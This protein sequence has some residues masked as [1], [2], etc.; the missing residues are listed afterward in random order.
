[1]FKDFVDWNTGSLGHSIGVST[2]FAISNPYK[3]VWTIVGDA[4]MEEG[5]IWEGLLYFRKK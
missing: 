5:S 3:K 2:G 4:E 1:M